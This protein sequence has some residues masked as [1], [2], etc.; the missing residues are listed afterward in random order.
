ME[1]AKARNSAVEPKEEE[2]RGYA[3]IACARPCVHCVPYTSSILM[4]WWI[5]ST[6]SLTNGA[7]AGEARMAA[8]DRTGFSFSCNCS[9]WKERALYRPH[10][11]SSLT[12]MNVFSVLI[13]VFVDP[14]PNFL[15]SV[16]PI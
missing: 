3:V 14:S 8:L 7:T 11:R 13:C 1:A 6:L 2:S 12:F 4:N 16:S 9:V 10:T 15:Q 5:F